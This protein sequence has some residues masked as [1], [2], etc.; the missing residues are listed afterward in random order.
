K[1]G[2]NTL[3]LRNRGEG[4]P[5]GHLLRCFL[6]IRRFSIGA[7]LDPPPG[8][9]GAI[10]VRR[11]RTVEA[12]CGTVSRPGEPRTATSLSH[13]DYLAFDAAGRRSAVREAVLR[14]RQSA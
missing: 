13:R 8:R 12:E 3:T 6:E 10:A 14:I 2:V 4:L 11:G 1:I 5:P 7:G 9:Y